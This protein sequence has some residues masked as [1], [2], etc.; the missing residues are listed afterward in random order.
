MNT[1]PPTFSAQG[2]RAYVS[3]IFSCSKET[4]NTSPPARHPAN[5]GGASLLLLDLYI[6]DLQR[7]ILVLNARVAAVVSSL[8]FCTQPLNRCARSSLSHPLGLPS[9][10]QAHRWVFQ[11]LPLLS[12]PVSFI[13]GSANVCLGS[14]LPPPSPWLPLS[15][16]TA[17]PFYCFHRRR[18]QRAS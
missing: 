6:S 13:A 5:W 16:S 9:S 17:A 8:G 11:R 1:S 10:A 12:L 4:A 14:T 2:R 7:I 18:M 15:A 3:P